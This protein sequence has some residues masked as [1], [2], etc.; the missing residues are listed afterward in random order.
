MNLNAKGEGG[1]GLHH[2]NFNLIIYC[3]RQNANKHTLTIL[4]A[5]K[6]HRME[7][8]STL[9]I[10]LFLKNQLSMFHVQIKLHQSYNRYFFEYS[11]FFKVNCV[12][13]TPNKFAVSKIWIG[14]CIVNE[15]KKCIFV[16]KMFF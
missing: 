16:Y 12:G 9:K 15:L 14:Q 2:W 1:G 13:T 4:C 5:P 3:L 6:M 10:S 7:L 11:L 8:T